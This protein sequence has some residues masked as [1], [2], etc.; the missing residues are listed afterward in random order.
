MVSSQSGSILFTAFSRS[1]GSFAIRTAPG[2]SEDCLDTKFWGFSPRD[3]AVELGKA[4][5]QATCFAVSPCSILHEPQWGIT[6]DNDL[7]NQLNGMGKSDFCSSGD[8]FAVFA[9]KSPELLGPEYWNLF[10]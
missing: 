5:W 4:I 2:A 6:W 1:T 10:P 7:T 3:V 9:R 8:F